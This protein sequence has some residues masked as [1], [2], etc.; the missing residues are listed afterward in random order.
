MLDKNNS[1]CQDSRP[2]RLENMVQN[3]AWGTRNAD[4]FIPDLLGIKAEPHETYAELWMGVHPKAPSA[5][6][7]SEHGPQHLSTW[8]SENLDERLSNKQE[9]SHLTGLPY[10]LKVL[11]AGEALSIQAHPNKTQAEILHQQDPEHYPD[12][13]HK[14]EIAI[15]LDHLDALVGFISD[16]QY[17][18][19]LQKYPELDALLTQNQ[20]G[21]LNLREGLHHIFDVWEHDGNV[22]SDTI[23]KLHEGLRLKDNPDE[24]E[25]LF[26]EQFDKRGAKD[27]GLI[28]IFLL[29]RIHLGPG[30]AIFLGP[31]VPHAYLKG[32][33]IECMANSDNVVRLGLT[34]KFCDA[35]ALRDILV[36]DEKVDYQIRPSL[37]GHLIEYDT[38]VTEF[39]IKSLDLSEGNSERVTSHSSLTMYLLVEGEI[40]LYWGDNHKTCTCVIKRGDS[41]ITPANL[42]DYEIRAQ[43][44]SKLYLVELP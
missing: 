2:Y 40:C 31:G 1:A 11:S 38:P 26:L 37:Q 8:I 9:H 32:N 25:Q 29:N 5:V 36:Y 17:A 4:A 20:H 15:A 23:Q 14:P 6:I 43:Q 28:F 42:S 24:S 7:A 33:I 12:G 16:S 18:E 34:D 3:Y 41:F 22:I 19:L 27:I 13:N 39:S 30:E 44:D 10:L 21:P 35:G